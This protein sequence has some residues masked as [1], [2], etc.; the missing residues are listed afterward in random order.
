[1][2]SKEQTEVITLK[3]WGELTFQQIADICQ[4]SINTI[5]ARYRLGLIKLQKKLKNLKK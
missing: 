2:L 3:I 1:T 5:A 4:C